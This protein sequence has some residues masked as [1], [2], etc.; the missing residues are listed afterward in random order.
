MKKANLIVMLGAVL[1]FA[2]I[3]QTAPAVAQI[4]TQTLDYKQGDTAL[5]GYLAYDEKL[6]GKRPG[7]LIVHHREGL[8]DFTRAQAQ[9]I[10]TLGYVAFAADI[11]GKGTRPKNAEEAQ[12]Q[13]RIY[14]QDRPLMRARA[15]AALDAM[16]QLAMIDASR[17]ATLG[18]CFGGTVTTELGHTGAPVVGMVAVHGSFRN[19]TPGAAKNMK[20]R[21]LILHGAEDTSAPLTEVDLVLKELRAAKI[22]FEYQLF[23]GATHGF[24][25]SN[26]PAN[27]RANVRS[28]AAM[29]QFF[30]EVLKN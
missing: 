11:F 23:S 26:S 12:Q 10:A 27:E 4:K 25:R 7:V 20:G 8:D 14:N 9:R 19:F 28:I 1:A 15:Q 18:Y 17:I 2:G 29:D 22:D 6:T 30:G 5:E 16:R 13:S 24:S 3:V 21:V